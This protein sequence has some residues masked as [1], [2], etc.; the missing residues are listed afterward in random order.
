MW[1]FLLAVF[2]IGCSGHNDAGY[3]GD[4]YVGTRYL[5][6][7]LGE[8]VAPDADPLIRFD[9]FDCTTFVETVLADNDIEKMQKIRY[10][11]GVLHVLTRNHFIETDWLKNNADIIENVSRQYART[12]KVKI[13]IDKKI[14]FKNVYN[15]D[16]DFAPETVSLEYIPYKYVKNIKIT[17]PLVVLFLNNSLYPR[18]KTGTDLLVRHMG[19]LLPDGTL[20]HASKIQ[21]RVVDVNFNEYV[22]RIVENKNNIGIMLLEIKK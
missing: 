10:K 18:K 6:N 12:K 11:N 17:Q 5:I 9:A 1:R 22:N 19:F 4:K 20:R 2:L 7:P 14:W 13:T 16:T 21:G 8:G 15:L 3:I